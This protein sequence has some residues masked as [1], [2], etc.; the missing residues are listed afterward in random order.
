MNRLAEAIELITETWKEF[1]NIIGK[2]TKAFQKIFESEKRIRNRNSPRKY[3][4]S[5][6]KAGRKRPFKKYSYFEIRRKNEPY[7]W[8]DFEKK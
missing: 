1:T 2:T 4:E 5:L 8:R 6:K 3:G 7:Q